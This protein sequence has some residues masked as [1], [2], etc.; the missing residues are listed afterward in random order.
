MLKKWC[1]AENKAINWTWASR[2]V[3]HHLQSPRA[4]STRRTRASLQLYLISLTPN[5]ST[6][7]SLEPGQMFPVKL[8]WGWTNSAK[9]IISSVLIEAFEKQQYIASCSL[10]GGGVSVCYTDAEMT[11]LLFHSSPVP[12]YQCDAQFNYTRPS[13]LDSLPLQVAKGIGHRINSYIT[14]QQELV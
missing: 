14:E 8:R 4:E 2:Q 9:Y 12:N 10:E 13:R 11:L 7:I 3:A 1:C 6:V 5:T